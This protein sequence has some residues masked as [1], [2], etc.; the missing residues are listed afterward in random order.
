MI[1]H[2]YLF[3][4]TKLKLS[5]FRPVSWLPLTLKH[6]F[7]SCFPFLPRS[8]LLN[9]AF[10]EI[11]FWC[12]LTA[13]PENKDFSFQRRQTVLTRLCKW[14]TIFSLSQKQQSWPKY[15]TFMG[16][17]QGLIMTCYWLQFIFI[18]SFCYILWALHQEGE[19][20][21]VKPFKTGSQVQP[22]S[23]G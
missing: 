20:F 5:L 15:S 22:G 13:T 1:K 23:T 21:P 11:V 7:T 3:A 4:C 17:T 6:I 9:S 16:N 12:Q 19:E 10:T 18:D 8:H 2:H 14:K